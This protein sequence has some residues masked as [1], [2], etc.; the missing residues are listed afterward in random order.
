MMGVHAGR[1]DSPRV[2]DRGKLRGLGLS[3][4]PLRFWYLKSKETWR[5]WNELPEACFLQL[6]LQETHEMVLGSNYRLDLSPNRPCCYPR[7]SPDCQPSAEHPACLF[8][9][10]RARKRSSGRKERV[11]RVERRGAEK[12]GMIRMGGK[13]L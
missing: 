10:E 4:L 1:G 6:S 7:V 11:A 8:P 9:I 12:R 3:R 2:I 13:F 5:T